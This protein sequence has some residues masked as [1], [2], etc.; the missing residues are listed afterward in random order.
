MK[1]DIDW[2]QP[3]SLSIFLQNTNKNMLMVKAI[4]HL[5]IA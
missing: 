3:G 5:R 2:E 1:S 4:A